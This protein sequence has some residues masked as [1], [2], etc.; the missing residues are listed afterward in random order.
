MKNIELEKPNHDPEVWSDPKLIRFEL[1][2]LGQLT[3]FGRGSTRVENVRPI[4]LFPLSRPD[5]WIA[6]LDATGR[7][8][9]CIDGLE[10]LSPEQRTILEQELENE[11]LFRS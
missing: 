10:M 11:S 8:V 6:I 7:E 2:S 4:R 9:C 5:H 1:D 3:M